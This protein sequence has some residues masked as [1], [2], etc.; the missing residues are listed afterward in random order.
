MLPVEPKYQPP[1]FNQ[2]VLPPAFSEKNLFRGPVLRVLPGA[3]KLDDGPRFRISEIGPEQAGSS[4][5]LKLG[6]E[7]ANTYGMQQKPRRVSPAD[8]DRPSSASS[9]IRAFR[10]PRFSGPM[11]RSR[12]ISSREAPLRNA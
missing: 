12:W 6:Y 11:L 8:S 2:R 3:I 10:L 7:A 4:W 5:N 1:L 9:R